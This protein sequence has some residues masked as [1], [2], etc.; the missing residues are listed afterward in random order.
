M[1]RIKRHYEL[2][3]C[4][5]NAVS[6]PKVW[7]FGKVVTL[8]FDYYVDGHKRRSGIRFVSTIA[9]RTT[10]ERYGRVGSHYDRLT[11]YLDSDWLKELKAHAS[12][13][14]RDD[15]E[16]Y[17]HFGIFLDSAGTFEVLS[18][19]FEL[20]PEEAASWESLSPTTRD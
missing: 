5:T 4:S 16:R 12:N 19:D 18:L 17:R 8:Y 6:D 20:L 11:E 14:Y 10:N 15:L 7:V 2:P 13:H 3:V 9:F 1:S